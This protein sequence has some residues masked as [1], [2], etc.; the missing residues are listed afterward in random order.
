MESTTI[1][2]CSKLLLDYCLQVD[3]GKRVYIHTTT[4]ALPL[5][6]ALYQDILERK[7]IPVVNMSFDQQEELQSR[8]AH[9]EFIKYINPEYKKAIEEF[10]AYLFIRA[11]FETSGMV[12]MSL[13]LQ[14]LRRQVMAAINQKYAQRT[15]SYDLRR[16]L[17]QYPTPAGAKDAGME[18]E[19]FDQF[20]SNACFLNEKE[21]EQSWKKLGEAQQHYVDYLNKTK[22]LTY[23]NSKSEISFSVDGRKWINSDGKNNMPSGEIYTSPVEDSVNGY[24]YFDF[25]FIYQ[26][27][28]V[29]GVSLRVK[30]GKIQSG[31][32]SQGNSVLQ[33]ILEVD[34]ARYFGEVAIGLNSNINRPTKNILF[35][36]K[37]AGTVHMAIGQSY[38]QCG[39]KNESAIHLDMIADMK[40]SGQ[41]LADGVL[42]YDQGK[43]LI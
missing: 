12:R 13:S 2:A 19:T 6:Q 21:P 34:G 17:C 28:M 41:I 24:I 25:P 15:G 31:E 22:S 11:P 14:N 23:I 33:E 3:R 20:V 38:L 35:D 8:Y 39:G 4:L 37:M 40:S 9:E 10:D 43:F 29:Q 42:I 7:A 1:T 16:T 5:V 36:E 27:Q 30:N 26:H 18:L 32:A